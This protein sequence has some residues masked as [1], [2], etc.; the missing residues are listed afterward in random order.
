MFDATYLPPIVFTFV[1]TKTTTAQHENG[2]AQG[3]H[4]YLMLYRLN[5]HDDLRALKVKQYA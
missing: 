5:K 3:N 1:E 4:F 2:P